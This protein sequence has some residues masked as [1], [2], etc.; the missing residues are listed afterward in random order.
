M[1]STGGGGGG[2]GASGLQDTSKIAQRLYTDKKPNAP[3]CVLKHATEQ[4]FFHL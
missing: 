1:T 4:L 2:G 3:L